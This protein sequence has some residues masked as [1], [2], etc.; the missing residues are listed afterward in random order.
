M[1]VH[2][3]ADFFSVVNTT[4]LYN[5]WLVESIDVFNRTIYTEGRWYAWMFYLAEGQHPLTLCRSRVS[6]VKITQN[7]WDLSFLR[8]GFGACRTLYIWCKVV[9]LYVKG[10]EWK[11]KDKKLF[12]WVLLVADNRSHSNKLKQIMTY[13]R[14]LRTLK[15]QNCSSNNSLAI[16]AHT[17]PWCC[18]VVNWESLPKL[19]QTDHTHQICK[20]SRSPSTATAL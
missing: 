20:K 2:L 11:F 12:W 19:P 6:Y 3:Y 16:T 18:Q 1:L 15:N 13:P 4:V 14:I 7:N 10:N 17:Q 5:L 8:W 9:T